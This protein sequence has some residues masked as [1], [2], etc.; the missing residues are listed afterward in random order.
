MVKMRLSHFGFIKDLDDIAKAGYDC[1]ELHYHE[2]MAMDEGEYK[3]ALKKIRDAN[4]TCEVFNNP[5]PLAQRIIDDDF[6]LCYYHGFLSKGADRAAEM[7][8]R[9]CNFGNGKTRCI[10]QGEDAV[11][12]NAKH[13]A[14]MEMLCDINAERN[15]TVLIEPLAESLTNFLHSI[16][17]VIDYQKEIGKKNIRPF[18]D[19]RWHIA[20]G[21]SFED[22][23]TYADHIA[24]VHID[25]PLLPFPERR[26]PAI[27]DGYDYGQLF[28]KLKEICYKGIISIEANTFNDFYQDICGGLKLF[29]HHGIVPYR[30][31]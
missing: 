14:F 15:I 5:V 4:I 3:K 7:G 19:L 27:G 9:Y 29:R 16:R 23:V 6:D 11:R 25:N 12:L 21:H 10:A 13:R 30:T 20:Q 1:A 26:V 17:Q 22:I 24:H 18:I 28:D 2:I 8:A 31:A